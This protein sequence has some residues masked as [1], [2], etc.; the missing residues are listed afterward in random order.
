MWLDFRYRSNA[1]DG[2]KLPRTYPV[3]FPPTKKDTQGVYI[4]KGI[5][6]FTASGNFINCSE[7]RIFEHTFLFKATCS[8]RLIIEL[9]VSFVIRSEIG[10]SVKL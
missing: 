8:D 1:N 4:N 9:V 6:P 10:F 5:Q 3:E 2:N 7:G